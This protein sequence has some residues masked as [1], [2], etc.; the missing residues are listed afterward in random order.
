VPGLQESFWMLPVNPISGWPRSGEIDI[1][2]IFHRYPDRAIPY[3]HYSNPWDPNRTNNYCL[4][5][6]IWEYHDYVLEWTPQTIKIS[7]DG[8]VCIDDPWSP[9]LQAGRAP[10]NAPFYL[11]LTQALGVPDN[12]FVPGTTPLPASTVVDYVRVY[13]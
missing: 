6:D 10:F 1:A 7:Y 8:V 3:V 5:D 13:E 12:A 11:T 4:I 2:E 9:I